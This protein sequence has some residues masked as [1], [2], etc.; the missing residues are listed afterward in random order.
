MVTLP[1]CAIAAIIACVALAHWARAGE[2]PESRVPDSF[3][4][5]ISGHELIDEDFA[6][7]KALGVRWVRRGI[8]W[9][10]IEKTKGEHDFT[11]ADA[12][13]KRLGE[14]DLGLVCVLAFGHPE[15]EPGMHRM[16]VRTPVGRKGFANYAAAMVGRYKD[17]KIVFEIWNESNSSFWKPEPN[18]DQYMDMLDEAVVAMRKADPKCVIVAPSLYHIGWPKAIKWYE[19]CLKRDIC[20]KVDAFSFHSYGDR[21]R[22]AEVERNLKWAADLRELM[23]KYGVPQDYPFVQSEY[24]INQNAPEFQ[25]KP[26]EQWESLQA[27]SVTRNYLVCLM[28]QMPINIHYEWKSRDESTRGDKGLLNRDRTTTV[29][30]DAFRTLLEKLDGCVFKARLD[31]YGASDFIV[32]F[33]DKQGDSR[34]AVWTTAAAHSVEIRIQGTDKV[35]MWSMTGQQRELEVTNGKVTVELNNGPQYLHLQ[36]GKLGDVQRA[37]GREN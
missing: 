26:K 7:M 23:G 3:G 37:A 25:E 19:V 5:N 18:A 28:L 24:G 12:F 1:R 35:S 14:H 11:A 33:A 6:K 29:A 20:K 31:G 8:S 36:G 32:A 17:R 10:S 2:L 30:Y 9:E 16:G 15:Y 34:L 21:G 13:V 22:N 4:V 27:Q